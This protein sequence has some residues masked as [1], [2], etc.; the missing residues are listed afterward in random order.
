MRYPDSCFMIRDPLRKGPSL[1]R[2]L[3]ERGAFG[4]GLGRLLKT[5]KPGFRRRPKG[6][7]KRKG[8]G[9]IEREESL[10]LS[11]QQARHKG[12]SAGHRGAEVVCGEGRRHRTGASAS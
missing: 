12:E 7:D 1:P 9:M 4:S 5:E 8:T 3:F 10:V 2:N 11:L 6:E